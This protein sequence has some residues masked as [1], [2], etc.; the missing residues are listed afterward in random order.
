MNWEAIRRFLLW[1]LTSRK[2]WLATS[3]VVA[4]WCAASGLDDEAAQAVVRVLGTVLPTVGVVIGVAIED[5]QKERAAASVLASS[6]MRL[7]DKPWVSAADTVQISQEQWTATNEALAQLRE[8]KSTAAQ[9]VSKLLPLDHA[10][11]IEQRV[12]DI[13]KRAGAK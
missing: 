10:K 5:G 9:S 11:A 6:T 12:D 3:S 7:V 13:L 1:P 2:V 4:S 8:L